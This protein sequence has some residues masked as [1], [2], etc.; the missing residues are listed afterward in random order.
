MLALD[1]QIMIDK[2]GNIY[3]LDFDRVFVSGRTKSNGF[4]S[5]FAKRYDNALA[6]LRIIAEWASG[7]QGNHTDAPYH[8]KARDVRKGVAV[9]REHTRNNNGLSCEALEIVR[10]ILSRKQKEEGKLYP[11][12]RVVFAIPSSIDVLAILY[13]LYPNLLPAPCIFPGILAHVGPTH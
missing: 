2:N 13:W 10:K 7:Q 11:M 4:V 1:F 6:S 9:V 5:N 12:V 3:H 8:A